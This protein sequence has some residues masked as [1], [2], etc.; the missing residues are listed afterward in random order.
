MLVKMNLDEVFVGA[1]KSFTGQV[2]ASKAVYSAA[3]RAPY[4]DQKVN[5]LE[6]QVKALKLQLSVSQR[7]IAD[8]HYAAKVLI[9][10]TG[11]SD[12]FTD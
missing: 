10:R 1:L 2:V 8:A 7:V 4:L 11:Q 5:D 6:S 3:I 12:L 9:E